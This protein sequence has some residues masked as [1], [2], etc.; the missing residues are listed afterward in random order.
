MTEYQTVEGTNPHAYVE[1]EPRVVTR[2]NDEDLMMMTEVGDNVFVQ[3]GNCRR[4][5]ERVGACQCKGGPVEPPFMR[6]WR[7]ERFKHELDTR[8]DPDYDLL[9]SVLEWVRERGYTVTKIDDERNPDATCGKC[10]RSIHEE[11]PGVPGSLWAHDTEVGESEDHE[12]MPAN[13]DD[14]RDMAETGPDGDARTYDPETG[15]KIEP[16]IDEGLDAALERVREEK[17]V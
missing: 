3:W 14:E 17:D 13:V 15:E 9:P 12:A 4:C 8:P 1:H 6:T 11:E 10:G 5:S 7:N 16:T 2:K